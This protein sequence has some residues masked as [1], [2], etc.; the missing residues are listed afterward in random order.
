MTTPS[1]SHATQQ[2]EKQQ[3]SRV[4][5]VGLDARDFEENTQLIR[6]T[7]KGNIEE[8]TALLVKGAYPDAQNIYGY[9]ALLTALANGFDKVAQV[10]LDSGASVHI[11]TLEGESALHLA[12][13]YCN[14]SMME[15]LLQCGAFLGVQDEEGDTLFHWVIREGKSETLSFLIAKAPTFLD[16]QNEDGETPLHLAA[17]LGEEETVETLL[18]GGASASIK[19]GTGLTPADHAFENSHYKIA[20]ILSKANRNNKGNSNQRHEPYH[21]RSCG[22]IHGEYERK[23]HMPQHISPRELSSPTHL[24]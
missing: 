10:L 19:D 18:K 15:K 22:D 3:E 5:Q 23:Y 4:P 16:K 20:H 7:A 6:E 8:V 11:S 1:N 2:Q 17:S 24:C 14:E 12:A 21:R 13:M 9:T